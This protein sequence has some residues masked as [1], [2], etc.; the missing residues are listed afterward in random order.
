MS[1]DSFVASYLPGAT[2]FSQVYGTFS[3]SDTALSMKDKNG[4]EVFSLPPNAI[5]AIKDESSGIYISTSSKNYRISF[6]NARGWSTSIKAIFLSPMF[7]FGAKNGIFNLDVQEKC[8]E[9]M[10]SLAKHG[11]PA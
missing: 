8:R 2:V 10:R 1:E 4:K 3:I 9:A 6:R 5:T 11:Y 7:S